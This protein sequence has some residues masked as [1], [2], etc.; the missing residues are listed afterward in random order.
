[1]E[2]RSSACPQ[3][4]FPARLLAAA[5]TDAAA[6]S[7]CDVSSAYA[8]SSASG[9]EAITACGDWLAVSGPPGGVGVGGGSCCP[10]GDG[11]G[12]LE[13]VSKSIRFPPPPPQPPGPRGVGVSSTAVNTAAAAADASR[14]ARSVAPAL[15]RLRASA[16]ADHSDSKGL[17]YI[18]RHVMN[19]QFDPYFTSVPVYQCTSVPVY[20]C[21]SV[22]VYQ[23]TSVPVYQFTSVPVYQCTGV[24]VYQCTLWSRMASYD[25]ASSVCQALPSAPWLVHVPPAPDPPAPALRLFPALEDRRWRPPGTPPPLPQAR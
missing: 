16:A 14:K 25:V 13:G 24:S 5:A 12:G 19:M 4:R 11:G 8:S 10:R 23:C 7:S 20:Q 3:Y 17:N 2:R 1:M 15:R 21:T 18:A 22:P 6:A 9:D